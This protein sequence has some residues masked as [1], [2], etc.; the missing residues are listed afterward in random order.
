M[1][2]YIYS[3]IHLYYLKFF[4]IFIAIVQKLNILFAMGIFN[5]LNICIGLSFFKGG[6]D[7]VDL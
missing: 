3:I 2:I 6:G 5:S 4:G 7:I 1:L